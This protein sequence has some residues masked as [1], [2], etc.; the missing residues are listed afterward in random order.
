MRAPCRG[1][2][3]QLAALDNWLPVWL[4]FFM[5]AL[6]LF[7]CFFFMLSCSQ[8]PVY[9]TAPFDGR[10]VSI[11]VSQFREATP[12]FY[13]IVLE[14][15]RIDFFVL[16]A[17]GEIVSYL[18]ACKECHTKKLGYRYE[19]GAMVCR[20]CNVGVP[21]ENLDTGIGG[22]YPIRLQGSRVGDTYTLS[23]EALAAGVKYF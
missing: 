1:T 19:K 17:H 3:L 16:L 14:G 22:C 18:D 6:I 9:R 13:T 7:S 2:H 4:E 10:Q 5:K 23:R 11:D 15:K 12:E 8:R 20:A 21:L